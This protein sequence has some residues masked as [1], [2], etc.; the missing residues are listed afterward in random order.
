MT[1]STS[2]L[3]A[4]YLPRA[5]AEAIWGGAVPFLA[6][7]FAPTGKA[8]A[9]GDGVRLSG[10]WAFTSGSRH[11]D[12]FAVGALTAATADAPPR[13]VVCF[14]PARDGRVVDNWDTLGLHGTGSHDLVVEDARVPASHVTSV[15]DRAPWADGPLYRVPLFGLLA[16]GI[17]ACGLGIAHAAL[18]EVATKLAAPASSGAPGARGDGPPSTLLHRY[19]ELRA[20]LDA[21]R[22]YLTTTAA[23]AATAATAGALDG[24]LRGELRLAASFVAEQCAEVV[25]A[26]FHL[27]GGASI[28]AGSPLGAALRDVE[29]MLT[30]RMVADRVRPAAARAL[31]GVGPVPADL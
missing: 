24:A 23:H 4:P 5:T 26:A 1:A 16:V 29:T 15:F 30:H 21:A 20:R 17:A 8:T 7:V 27:G 25:R 18:A 28:R 14:V 19:A 3:M 31:L 9:D 13:H 11:A 2:T 22:A 12:W 10:R 6:G